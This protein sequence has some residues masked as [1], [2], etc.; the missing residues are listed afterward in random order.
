MF[1]DRRFLCTIIGYSPKKGE[2]NA[3]NTNKIGNSES[4][5]GA[6]CP[7]SVAQQRPGAG[8][9]MGKRDAEETLR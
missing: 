2:K 1:I 7:S 8:H 6:L 3:R 4:T 5:K 9:G